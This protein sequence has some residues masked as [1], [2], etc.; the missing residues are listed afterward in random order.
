MFQTFSYSPNPNLLSNSLGG[1]I[2]NGARL[3]DLY[4]NKKQQSRL[5]GIADLAR[6]G[7]QSPEDFNNLGAAMIEAGSLSGGMNAINTPFQREQIA[8]QREFQNMKLNAQQGQQAFQNN[9]ATEKLRLAQEQAAR[10]ASEQ[11]GFTTPFQAVDENGNTVFLQ[12]NDRGEA[13]PIEGFKPNNPIKTIDLGT[14]I[15]TVDSRTNQVLS[16][17]PKAN[18]QAEFDKSFGRESGKTHAGKVTDFP[19]LKQEADVMIGVID[20]IL[21]DPNLDSAVGNVQS[22]LPDLV[23]GQ[24]VVDFRAKA[25]QLEGRTF[26]QAFQSLKGGGQITEAEGRKAT[27]AIARLN[28]AQSEES[29]R[30][31]LQELRD[32]VVNARARADASI[33]APRLQNNAGTTITNNSNGAITD[34]PEDE[35]NELLQKY[36]N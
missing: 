23:A 25:E 19:R 6:G 8:Q 18:Q 4:N 10:Q 31:A 15:Q 27:A 9:I 28:Q 34:V 7:L 20:G 12:A 30:A 3:V 16:T 36:G 13:R 33:N 22:R 5:A 35:L 17:V 29:Y 14:H 32:I 2:N 24:G 21:D 26:L 1:G 11:G